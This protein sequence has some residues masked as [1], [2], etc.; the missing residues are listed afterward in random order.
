VGSQRLELGGPRQ[1]IVLAMLMLGA[2]TVVS[3][4]RLLE[5]IYGEDLPPT[6][7]SQG[8]I[9]ISW[10]RRLFASHGGAAT[11]S[12]RAQGYVIEVGEGSLD[13]VV[14]EKLLT[15]ARTA[16]GAGHLDRA[17]ASYRDALRLWR[18]PALGGIDSRLVRAAASRL[19]EQRI[20][21]I[22]DQLSLELDLGRHHE[23]VGELTRH[24]RAGRA[25]CG[26]RRG[27]L[28]QGRRWQDQPC[29]ACGTRPGGPVPGRAAVR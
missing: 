10:L 8:Q 23:V 2:N 18:G 3:T 11:I 17:V 9:S 27:D 24:A 14:F 25:A 20:A 1:Q 7:R 6:S 16:A 15:A 26:T 19:D 22:E 13:S 12:T 28:R 4:D 5:A 29:R 21:A